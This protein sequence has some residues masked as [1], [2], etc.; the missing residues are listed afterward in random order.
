MWDTSWITSEKIA[1]SFSCAVCIEKGENH[2]I[3]RLIGTFAV[4]RNQYYHSELDSCKAHSS[5]S[6]Y[7]QQITS[8]YQHPSNLSFPPSCHLHQPT[9]ARA[10]VLQ[11]LAT[12]MDRFLP[13]KDRPRVLTKNT[14]V[15]CPRRVPPW[16]LIKNAPSVFSCRFPLSWQFWWWEAW[17]SCS[18][19]MS[20]D[21]NSRLLPKPWNMILRRVVVHPAKRVRLAVL[22]LVSQ[23]IQQT[24]QQIVLHHPPPILRHHHHHPLF[25]KTIHPPA[26]STRGA[27]ISKDSAVLRQ[28]VWHWSVV[29][30]QIAL[31]QHDFHETELQHERID[32]TNLNSLQTP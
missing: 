10:A 29:T 21:R 32:R 20:L 22:L 15:F 17:P 28:M 9:R 5:A 27:Q 8:Q 18:I 16:L 19:K 4:W 11:L 7:T 30:K 24:T 23:S 3:P 1:S 13:E 14:C 2:A 26:R 31:N 12:T 25:P 6:R